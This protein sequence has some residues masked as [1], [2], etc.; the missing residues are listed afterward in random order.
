MFVA[1]REKFI[2][3]D[4]NLPRARRGLNKNGVKII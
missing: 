2:G 4:K 3:D 1:K